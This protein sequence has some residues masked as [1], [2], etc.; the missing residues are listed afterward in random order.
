VIGIL[1]I[2]M[3]KLTQFKAEDDPLSPF[4]DDKDLGVMSYASKYVVQGLQ[5]IA[6]DKEAES[7]LDNN[8][9][10]CSDSWIYIIGYT[11]SLF[12]IQL[13][14]N[15]IMHHKFTRYAQIMYALMVPITV[16]AFKCASLVVDVD[17]EFNAFDVT[18]L[19]V[20]GVGVFIHNIY[21]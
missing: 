5:C 3:L 18:G 11:I 13:N 12:V 10:G 4:K 9:K 15:S 7:T 6:H 1:A 2:P 17:Q 14:L 19:L 16:V 20:V 8:Y 21:K